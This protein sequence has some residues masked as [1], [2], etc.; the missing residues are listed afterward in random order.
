ME[1]MFRDVLLLGIVS[2]FADVS[3]EM[4][5]P[6]LPFFIY[7]LVAKNN[8]AIAGLAIGLITGVGDAISNFA[9][10]FSGRLSDK[11]GKRKIFMFAGY[12][13]S[14]ISKLFFPFAWHWHH[15]LFL[16]SVERIGKGIRGPPRDAL[17]GDL[18]E[19]RRGEAYGIHRALDTAGAVAGC[20]LALALLWWLG[21]PMDVSLENLAG[22]ENVSRILRTILI[23][24]AL[25]AFLALPPIFFVK[26]IVSKRLVGKEKLSPKLKKFIVI[27]TLFYLGNFS[28]AFFLLRIGIENIFYAILLYALFNV[29]YASLA[30]QFGKLSDKIGRRLTIS[31]GYLLFTFTCIGFI[32]TPYFSYKFFI[33][34]SIILFILYG[35][36]YALIEG[37]QRAFISDLSQYKGFAQGVFQASIGFASIPAGI[38]AGILWDFLPELTFIYGA[39]LSLIA[40][41]L[42]TTFE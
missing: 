34:S 2:F 7:S 6:I 19:K 8:L 25:I 41:I 11:L 5:M 12:G 26:E 24:A 33:L 28:Y 22:N 15:L 31:F 30:R 39:I 3:S 17:I 32:F 18:Y 4:I 42:L 20:L 40:V 29:V 23:I 37:N 27:A 9:K 13:S 10:V 35:M 1:K 36:V 21:F 16:R 14:A 38:I